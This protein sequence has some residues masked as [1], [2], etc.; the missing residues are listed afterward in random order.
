M[1]SL[2]GCNTEPI[3]SHVDHFGGER[4]ANLASMASR[5]FAVVDANPRLRATATITSSRVLPMFRVTACCMASATSAGGRN[6]GFRSPA[7]RVPL[8]HLTVD[9]LLSCDAHE[10]TG[11]DDRSPFSR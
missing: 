5:N 1:K 3:L 6:S 8:R 11:L 9:T 10:A 7:D 2:A 4:S